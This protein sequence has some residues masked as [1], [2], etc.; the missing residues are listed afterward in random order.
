[1]QASW[2]PDDITVIPALCVQRSGL[3]AGAS[4]M[5]DRDRKTSAVSQ[6]G[7]F[8]LVHCMSCTVNT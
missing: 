6:F 7:Y 8:P 1:M 5:R 3:Q 4:A 2:N